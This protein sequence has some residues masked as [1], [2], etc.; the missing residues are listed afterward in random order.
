[1]TAP[2]LLSPALRNYPWGSRTAIPAFLGQQPDGKPQ[3]ELWF[4]AHR[5]APSLLPDRPGHPDLAAAIT[6]DPVTELGEASL[7]AHGPELP[8][9]LK[10]LAAEQAL[11]VQVHPT[12][13]QAQHGHDREEAAAVPL[14]APH[15]TF[16]D[17]NHKPELLCA[18]EPFE[19]LCGFREPARTA[20]LLDALAVPELRRW[21]AVLRSRP[22]HEALSRTLRAALCAP[23]RLMRT[24][25]AALPRLTASPGPWNNTAAA[26]TAVAK[27]FLCDPGLL[28]ALLLNHVRLD[29]GEAL[30]L[31]AGV[32][33][34]YLRG[35]GVEIM[36]NSDNVLRCGLTDK[37]VDTV[38]LADIVDC[39][40]M[41][42]A[43]MRPT[44]TGLTGET[45]FCSPAKEF[46]LSRLETGT[47]AVSVTD[48][49]PQVLLCLAGH[50]RLT[51]G[52][53]LSRGAAAFVPAGSP[54]EVTGAGAVLYRARVPMGTAS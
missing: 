49:G 38:L 40:P 22:A 47:E 3:A 19:A 28:A 5:A 21:S 52:P 32:P 54:C 50:V 39:T 13:K 25:S 30:Y 44:P 11:S 53:T 9:L 18:L 33:H 14:D 24:V 6:A 10:L 17:R 27:D 4:G 35:T 43:I 37:H 42:P 23:E 36:A 7:A 16:K 51:P 29:A 45:Q 20:E 41:T 31:G 46:V 26:Y 48:P 1:M 8:F 15:R 34:A 2:S 12:R